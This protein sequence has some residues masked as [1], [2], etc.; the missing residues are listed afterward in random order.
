M[1]KKKYENREKEM[2]DRAR[3]MCFSLKECC[4]VYLWVCDTEEEWL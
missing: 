3:E 1:N 4:S 2:E